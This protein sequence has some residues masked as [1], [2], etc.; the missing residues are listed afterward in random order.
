MK[1][2]EL[3]RGGELKRKT[4]VNPVNR[5]RKAANRI[6]HY[7]GGIDYDTWIRRKRCVRCV[8]LGRRQP[9]RTVAAHVK[10]K[11]A[12]GTWEDLIPLC[13]SCHLHQHACGIETFEAEIGID[14]VAM[15]AALVVEHKQELAA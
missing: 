10:S 15:A 7:T 13:F 1:R 8:A 9:T 2:T 3:K 6:K 14:L 12:G 5:E 4:R 11:G